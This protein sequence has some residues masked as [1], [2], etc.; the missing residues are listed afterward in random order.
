[1]KRMS[2]RVGGK[3]C[4]TRFINSE[5]KCIRKLNAFPM[6][7]KRVLPQS[8]RINKVYRNNSEQKETQKLDLVACVVH[9]RELHIV[10]LLI[11]LYYYYYFSIKEISIFFFSKIYIYTFVCFVRSRAHQCQISYI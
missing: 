6:I 9:A 7:V 5:E 11:S 3:G 4:G 1:M 8:Q 2:D 10:C